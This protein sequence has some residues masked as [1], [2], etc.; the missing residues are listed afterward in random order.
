MSHGRT[1]L[2]NWTPEQAARMEKAIF[3][4][5]HRLHDLEM[6][7]DE[8]L[9]KLIDSHP[10]HALGINTMGADH[11][12]VRIGRKVEPAISRRRSYSGPPSKVGF[13]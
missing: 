6:F 12:A 9:I 2:E 8:S 4:A 1:L 3:V 13:G 10:R 11:Y 7:G 5:Q